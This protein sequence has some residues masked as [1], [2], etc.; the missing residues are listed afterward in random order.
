MASNGMTKSVWSAAAGKGPYT[1]MSRVDILIKAIDQKLKVP[2]S[3]GSEVVFKDIPENRDALEIYKAG[4]ENVKTRLRTQSMKYVTMRDIPKSSIFGGGFGEKDDNKIPATILTA[5]FE[6][7]QC[8]Y[9]AAMTNTRVKNQQEV[10]MKLLENAQRRVFMGKTKFKDVIALDASWHQSSYFVAKKLISGGYISKSYTFHRDDDI[11]NSIYDAKKRAF[12][13]DSMANLNNDKWNPGD[14]WAVKTGVDVKKI[15]KTA[16]TSVK[17]INNVVMKAFFDKT[18][19]GISL[20][21][22]EDERK[23]KS[24]VQN[25]DKARA[26]LKPNTFVSVQ[27]S[28]AKG[29]FSK[30]GGE[31]VVND[32]TKNKK[33]DVRPASAMQALNMEAML[34]TA[35]GGKA[36]QGPQLDAAK[37]FMNYTYPNNTQQK[38]EDNKIL[39]EDTRTIDNFWMMVKTIQNSPLCIDTPVEE[40]AFKVAVNNQPENVIHAKLATTYVF[41]GLVQANKKQ[42]DDFVDYVANYMESTLPESSVYLKVYQ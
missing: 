25:D 13:N 37:R 34:S 39:N 8:L 5:R 26:N 9:C 11:M 4:D 23:I 3:D 28:G 41:Y 33:I 21:K 35:R 16:D 12:L 42:R 20:K 14:I 40:A 29:F 2:I 30:Q 24:V 18:I 10:T 19:M 17:K 1:G 27:L 36:G 7:L 38:I 15:F 22:V 31:L 32:S 6:S